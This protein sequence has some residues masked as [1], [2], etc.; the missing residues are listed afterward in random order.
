[1]TMSGDLDPTDDELREHLGGPARLAF[2]AA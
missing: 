2:R 1:M